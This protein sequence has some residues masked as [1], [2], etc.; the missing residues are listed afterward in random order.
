[1]APPN[2]LNLHTQKSGNQVAQKHMFF[3]GPR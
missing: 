1:M 3:D 2:F